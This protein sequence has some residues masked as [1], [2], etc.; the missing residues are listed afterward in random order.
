MHNCEY[1][2]QQTSPTIEEN[3]R[4]SIEKD[5]LI[6]NDLRDSTNTFK[7]LA[8]KY[9]VSP[10]YISNLFDAF[11]ILILFFL[12]NPLITSSAAVFNITWLEGF[13]LVIIAL[14]ALEKQNNIAPDVKP[15]TNPVITPSA[16]SL[17]K[18]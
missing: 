18:W 3:R 16:T 13:I 10:T 17:N 14:T 4:I 11:C 2:Y 7:K 5:V 8:A 6:L 1:V 15:S 12:F 9:D